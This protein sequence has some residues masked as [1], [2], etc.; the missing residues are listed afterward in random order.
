MEFGVGYLIGRSV[1][2]TELPVECCTLCFG[3]DHPAPAS[4]M[5]APAQSLVPQDYWSQHVRLYDEAL[6][7]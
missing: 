7:F 2:H 3:M 1:K 6:V 5:N 4:A